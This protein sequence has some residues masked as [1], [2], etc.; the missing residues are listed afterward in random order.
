M[1]TVL[2]VAALYA[3]VGLLF[4]LFFA[5]RGAERYDPAVKN[6]PWGFRLLIVPGAMALWPFLIARTLRGVGEGQ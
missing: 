2:L 3:S 5:L 4:A 1:E 6:S